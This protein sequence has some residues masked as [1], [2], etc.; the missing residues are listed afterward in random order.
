M[1]TEKR[2]RSPSSSDVTPIVQAFFSG[3]QPLPSFGV[4][5]WERYCS[6]VRTAMTFAHLHL[7]PGLP[8]MTAEFWEGA[9]QLLATGEFALRWLA[10]GFLMISPT[11]PAASLFSKLVLSH[12]SLLNVLT[13]TMESRAPHNRLD[14]VAKAQGWLLSLPLA[15]D[16][17]VPSSPLLD[18]PPLRNEDVD[19]YI[20]C[21]NTP[22]G[23]L[24]AP[25]LAAHLGA[26]G[27]LSEVR[28]VTASLKDPSIRA[29][30]V[31]AVAN[32]R[33]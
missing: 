2:A 20:R 9:Q 3:C 33:Q 32:I 11:P 29:A 12:P 5:H 13:R 19:E 7:A 27:R 10:D 16:T 15:R 30:C 14:L 21:L 4:A 24:I 1:D 17:R 8:E 6:S 18:F 26:E 22:D 28:Y 25:I 23:G 31:A